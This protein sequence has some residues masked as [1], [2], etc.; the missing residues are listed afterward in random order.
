MCCYPTL[1]PAI[2]WKVASSPDKLFI[3]EGALSRL[4]YNLRLSQTDLFHNTRFP[5][6][7]CKARLKLGK[8]SYYWAQNK[9]IFE[10]FPVLNR[11]SMRQVAVFTAVLSKL[12]AGLRKDG[13]KPVSF[14]ISA[15]QHTRDGTLGTL[16]VYMHM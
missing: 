11:S 1:L 5:V 4:N 13:Y 2:Q 14:C 3:V 7:K 8:V 10:T 9:A 12:S 6:F 15:S 16:L